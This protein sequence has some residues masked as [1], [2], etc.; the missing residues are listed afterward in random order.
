MAVDL[1]LQVIQVPHARMWTVIELLIAYQTNVYR[2]TN[3]L[4]TQDRSVTVHNT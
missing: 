1:H 4:S 3:E 2:G